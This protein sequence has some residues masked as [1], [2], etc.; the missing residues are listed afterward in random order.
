MHYYFGH[1]EDDQNVSGHSQSELEV[2]DTCTAFELAKKLEHQILHGTRKQVS[3][4]PE[5]DKSDH[6]KDD[7]TSME[8]E[9]TIQKLPQGETVPPTKEKSVATGCTTSTTP[10]HNDGS[11][12][13][14][15]M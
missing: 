9:V 6:P 3:K 12:R 11:D 13:Y 14:A 4:K 10:T 7:T 2:E 8:V 5:S 1:L 15:R